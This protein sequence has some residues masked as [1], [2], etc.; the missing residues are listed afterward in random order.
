MSFN[1]LVYGMFSIS[2]LSGLTEKTTVRK[3]IE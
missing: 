1:V 3:S 2:M